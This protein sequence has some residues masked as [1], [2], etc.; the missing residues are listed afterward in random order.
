[1]SVRRLKNGRWQIDYYPKGRRGRRIQHTLPAA[2]TTEADA[3]YIEQKLRQAARDPEARHTR[4]ST[5]ATLWPQYLDW[6]DLHRAPGSYRDIKG[7][8]K[9]HIIPHLGAVLVTDLTTGHID[10]YKRIRKSQAVTNR[11]ITKE[12]YYLSGF[13]TWCQ[14]QGIDLTRRPRIEKLPHTRP[15]PLVLSV[16]EVAAIILASAQPYPTLWGMLFYLGLRLTEATTLQWQQIDMS[17]KTL[18]ITGK[19]GR[20]N[21]LPIPDPLFDLLSTLPQTLPWVFPSRRTDG[22]ITD[23]R[24]ALA[25]AC[26]KAGITKRVYPHLLRHSLATGLLERGVNLRVIQEILG[27]QQISTTEWYTQVA[28][29]SKQAALKQLTE[30]SLQKGVDPK[31]KKPR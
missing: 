24:K 31:K 27:H 26:E 5:V 23:V 1:M 8:G 30:Q 4:I 12:L 16:D 21:I 14:R 28:I 6:Y 19:G 3:R 22:H 25:R 9:N 10:V 15:L 7:V 29:A 18:T 20:R 2:V 17:A 13:L 11:T